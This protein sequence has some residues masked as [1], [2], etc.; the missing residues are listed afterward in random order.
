MPLEDV[1][2]TVRLLEIIWNMAHD[3][4]TIRSISG[5]CDTPVR[6]IAMN[7]GIPQRTLENWS[8]GSRAP[9][10]WQLPLLAYAVASDDLADTRR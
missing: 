10:E 2:Q 3:G 7:Y 1:T 8:D 4:I 6:Q 9:S 5:A